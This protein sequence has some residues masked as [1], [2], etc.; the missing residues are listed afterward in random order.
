MEMLL[1][2]SGVPILF[3]MVVGLPFMV[4]QK[5]GRVFF[6]EYFVMFLPVVIWILLTMSGLGHQ[7][8]S[9]IVEVFIVA[10][11]VTIYA[12]CFFKVA[13]FSKGARTSFVFALCL[14]PVA[15]RLFFPSLPE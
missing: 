3:C 13:S 8:L 10:L 1:F 4:L 11:I 6:W 12:V 9:N 15:L 7:S 2:V 14:L 5:T